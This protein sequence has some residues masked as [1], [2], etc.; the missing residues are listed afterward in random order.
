MCVVLRKEAEDDEVAKE[1]APPCSVRTDGCC[2]GVSAVQGR[3]QPS[4]QASQWQEAAAFR[5]PSKHTPPLWLV[6]VLLIIRL[7]VVIKT[8]TFTFYV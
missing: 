6:V 5:P 3:P 2:G 4:G 7:S 8:N 1:A